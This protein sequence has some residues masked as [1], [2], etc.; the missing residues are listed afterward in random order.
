LFSFQTLK[1]ASFKLLK[2]NF[3]NSDGFISSSNHENVLENMDQDDLVIFQMTT[4]ITSNSNDLFT[5]HEIKE[6]ARQSTHPT[7]EVQ[8]VLGTM[9][10]TPT[11]FKL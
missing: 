10:I 7:I 3:L 9:Q 1:D 2:K 8:D 11:R 4:T 6:E 5:S